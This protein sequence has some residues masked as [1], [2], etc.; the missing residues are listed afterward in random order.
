VVDPWLESTIA[1]LTPVSFPLFPNRFLFSL[2]LFIVLC[3][4]D[5]CYYINLFIMSFLDFVLKIIY[6]IFV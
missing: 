3:L 2:V 5:F 4:L 1:T 6:K